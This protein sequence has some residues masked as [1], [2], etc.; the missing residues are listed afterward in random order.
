V[1]AVVS[2][3]EARTQRV[4]GIE[5][6]ISKSKGIEFGSLIHQFGADFAASPFSPR[7]R[8]IFVEID[9][10]AKQRLP[11]RGGKKAAE[12]T[13]NGKTARGSGRAKKKKSSASR[14]SAT[15]KKDSRKGAGSGKKKSVTKRIARRKP[16]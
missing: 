1:L 8:A 5:R 11:K 3:A 12:P 6:A 15:G 2:D 4:P 13:T 16:R 9:P 14:A 7:V 10:E